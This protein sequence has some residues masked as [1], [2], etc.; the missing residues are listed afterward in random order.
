[1]VATSQLNVINDL[2]ALIGSFKA[3]TEEISGAKYVTSNLAIPIS[4]LVRQVTDQAT[5]STTLGFT[6]REGLLK[7]IGEKLVLF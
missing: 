2:F 5:I 6:V 4:N 7:G 3:V 1:M